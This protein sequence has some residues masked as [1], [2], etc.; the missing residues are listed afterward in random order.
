L[1][2]PD[3]LFLLYPSN[4][5]TRAKLAEA[6]KLLTNAQHQNFPTVTCNG[7]FFIFVFL[8]NQV[9]NVEVKFLFEVTASCCIIRETEDLLHSTVSFVLIYTVFEV[10]F[11]LENYIAEISLSQAV[12]LALSGGEKF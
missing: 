3:L 6:G 8:Y 11:R 5:F 10:I 1:E 12:F 7:L 4:L 9:K 2:A